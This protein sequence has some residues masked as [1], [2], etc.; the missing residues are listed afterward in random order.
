MSNTDLRSNNSGWV[1]IQD[2]ENPEYHFEFS[3][4]YEDLELFL[5]RKGDDLE[6]TVD[7]DSAHKGEAMPFLYLTKLIPIELIKELISESK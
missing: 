3:H 4:Y 7:W 2:S 5:T 6:I 1:R